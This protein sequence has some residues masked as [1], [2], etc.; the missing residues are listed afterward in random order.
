LNNF[1]ILDLLEDAA[2][3]DWT[4]KGGRMMTMNFRMLKRGKSGLVSDI[5]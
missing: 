5:G 3:L 4:E 2:D 1:G